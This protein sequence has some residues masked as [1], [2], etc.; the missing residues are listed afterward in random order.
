MH[1]H[2][3]NIILRIRAFFITHPWLKIISLMLAIVVWF[4]VKGEKL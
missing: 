3:K 1:T 4:Y 2:H